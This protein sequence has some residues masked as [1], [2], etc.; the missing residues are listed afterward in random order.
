MFLHAN[1]IEIE[2][3]ETAGFVA[4]LR[5]A[6]LEGNRFWVTAKQ[7]ILA[8]GAIEIPRLLLLSNRTQKTGLGNQNDLV[9]RFFMEHPHFWSGLYV[10]SSSEIFNKTA[11]YSKIQTVKGLPILGKLSLSEEV[12]RRERLLNYVAELVPRVVLKAV[13]NPFLY[14]SVESKGVQSLR[15]IRSELHSGRI[16]GDLGEHLRN[17]AIGLDDCAVT[18]YRNIKKRFLRAV[19]KRKLQL[20]RLANMSE[21]APNPQSRV[22]LGTD[23]DSLGQRRVRLDWRLSEIDI[24]SAVRSQQILDQELRRAGLGRLYI[25]L[26]EEIP[27]HLITGGWHHMGTTRM[28]RDPKKGVVDENC[29]VHG[30]SN[31]YI[32]GPSVFPTGGY[33]NPSLTI[34]ALTLRLADQV[35]EILS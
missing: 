26:N 3:N 5:T 6:C 23:C 33:A 7:F 14:P 13:L 16:P 1:V 17:I 18:A 8:V 19:D 28:H 31:L 10:P 22:T 11:L 20:F 9:G 30:M 29:R 15:T 4:R 35:K 24:M 34:V 32:A 25:E 2:T 21:Q 27:P 12:Q